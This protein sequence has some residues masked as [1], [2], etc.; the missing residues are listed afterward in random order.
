M[1]IQNKEVVLSFKALSD[2][3]RMA[4]LDMLADGELCACKILEHFQFTQPTLSYHMKLLC[5]SGIV[6]GRRD[7]AWMKYSL[8]PAKL[9]EIAA[10][11]DHICDRTRKSAE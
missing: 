11:L 6:L 9:T 8:N 1:D 5:D 2:E 7:G 3:T 4:I 10:F